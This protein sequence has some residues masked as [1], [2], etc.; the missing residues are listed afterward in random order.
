MLRILN[1]AEKPSVASQIAQTLSRSKPQHRRGKSKYNP[2][3]EFDHYFNNQ[4]CRMVVTSVSGHLMKLDFPQQ[5]QSWNMIDPLELFE[6]PVERFVDEKSSE[7]AKTIEI[8]AKK[9]RCVVL[10]L[11][12]DREGENISFE[13]LEHC[14]KFNNRIQYKRAIFNALTRQDLTRAWERLGIP[15]ELES[16]S[17][18]VRRELDLRTGAVFTRFQ[19]KLLQNMF[20]GFGEKQVISYGS[21]Q[22][23]TLGFVVDRYNRRKNFVQEKYY[24]I[25]VSIKN[26]TQSQD[27]GQDQDQ[28]SNYQRSSY[29]QGR[30]NNNKKLIKFDWQ[31][32]RLFDKFCVAV[33]YEMCV[34]SPQAT[35]LSIF[36]KPEKKYRPYPLNTV[37]L[38]RRCS[39]RLRLNA[40]MIMNIAESLYQK[41]YISYPRTETNSFPKTINV[42]SLISVQQNDQR[43]SN[44]VNKL[45]NGNK[46]CPPKHGRFSD[47]SHPPIYPVKPGNNLQGNDLR[48]YE[49]IARHF[50]AC[51]SQDAIGDSTV[52]TIGISG[53]KF[54]LKGLIIREYNFLEIYKYE[55]WSDITIPNFHEGQTF[56]PESILF[57]ESETQP[58]NLL[59]EPELIKLMDKEG[60]GTDATIADHISK[61]QYRKYVVKERNLYFKPTDLG[62]ALVESYDSLGFQFSKP[63]LRSNLEFDLKL[64]ISGQKNKN[65]VLQNNIKLYKDA[66]LKTINNRNKFIAKLRLYF[67]INPNPPIQSTKQFLQIMTCPKCGPQTK[68]L[69]RTT[70]NGKTYCGCRNYPNCKFSIWPKEN[71]FSEIKITTVICQSCLRNNIK[72]F[73]C[74]CSFNNIP[75]ISHLEPFPYRACIYCDPEI[76]EFVSINMG[77]TNTNNSNS[78]N[79]NSNSQQY[80][81]NRNTNNSQYSNNTNNNFNNYSN[82]INRNQNNQ[83][84]NFNNNNRNNYNNNNNNNNYNNSNN[85]YGGNNNYN[86]RNNYNNNNNNNNYNNSGSN[87]NNNNNGRGRGR[88]RGRGGSRGGGNSRKRSKQ[89]NNNSN[90]KQSRVRKCSVCKQP[91]HDKR[92]CPT[93]K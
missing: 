58:P 17:V 47:N 4:K 43:F 29:N 90:M 44:Y 31:R 74:D 30:N 71:V 88:G 59:T 14:Q 41:G 68:V 86:N 18:D 15:N 5:Y 85:N 65:D 26:Q 73:K 8:E 20:L 89:K 55:R 7:I 72:S 82:Q 36:K 49:F 11:D 13:V 62:L 3:W 42:K 56:I 39:K 67:Q 40:T 79:R 52:V 70:K 83:F 50:L 91:G 92:N 48:V 51:C 16:I 77:N 21:C 61:V 38:Q 63:N 80:N 33:L 46:F 93:L 9:A 87:Y 35:V 78:Q 66:F 28:N 34:K 23:P 60:I 45:L 64:I 27:E 32:R 57:Q 12:C 24:F 6:A 75:M 2:I 81:Q 84:N 37:E 54:T 22:F 10:W 1:V 25:E 19:S 69:L 76:A 53:E